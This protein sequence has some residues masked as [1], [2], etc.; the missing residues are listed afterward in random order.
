MTRPF[1]SK[2]RISDFENF[3]RHI[4]TVIALTKE[5]VAEGHPVDVQVCPNFVSSLGTHL[6]SRYF[7]D[8]ICRFTLDSTSEYLFGQDVESLSAG[9]PYPPSSNIPNSPQYENHPSNVFV[10]AFMRAQELAGKR[11]RYGKYWALGEFW[12]NKVAPLRKIV[13][14]Y[15][16][17]MVRD[18]LAK[19]ASGKLEKDEE[20]NLLATLVRET[21]GGFHPSARLRDKTH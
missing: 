19:K 7:Q 6:I 9:L 21:E 18:A 3:E 4:T 17:P 8:L 10:R 15:V 1:F 20:E 14:E 2:D 11:A 5:R 13:D 12:S 16:E